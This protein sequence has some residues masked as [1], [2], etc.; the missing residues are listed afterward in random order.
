M[1]LVSMKRLLTDALSGRYA[2]CYCESWNLESFQAVIEAAEEM[3]SP[4]ISGF[5]G[6]FLMHP[7]RAAPERLTYY[8]GF[9]RALRESSV[10][11]AFLLNETDNLAQIEEGIELGFNAVMIEGAHL[12]AEAYRDLVKKVVRIAHARNVSVEAQ[13]GHLPNGW[14]ESN[15][16][17]T[18]PKQA[19][20]FVEETGIDALG[21]SIGNVHI[22]TQGKAAIDVASLRKIRKEVEVPLVVHGG[23]GF[24]AECA[25]EVI[26]LGVAKFNFGTNLKQTYLS[27]IREKLADYSEPMNPHPFLGMGG[28]KDIFIAA[29]RAVKQKVKELIKAYGYAGAARES[30]ADRVA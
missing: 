13:I 29:R 20:A 27:T 26:G 2:V 16:E 6:G 12:G 30:L 7:T 28:K 25:A 14:E 24:P 22:L 4:V 19:R 21:I 5:N 3:R 1:P 18:D 8:A 17:P 11:V 15:G 23:T 10:P 9:A